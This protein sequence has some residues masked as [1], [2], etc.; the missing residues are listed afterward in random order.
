[1]RGPSER[2]CPP[3]SFMCVAVH[4][5]VLS[6]MEGFSRLREAGGTIPVPSHVRAPEVLPCLVGFPFSK[7]RAPENEEDNTREKKKTFD[8]RVP[9]LAQP[10]PEQASF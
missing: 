7:W 8:C 6:L 9:R 3:A 1:M 2:G 4:A 10:G 5:C